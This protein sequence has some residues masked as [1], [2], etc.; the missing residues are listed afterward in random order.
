M[1]LASR[2]ERMAYQL[3]EGQ[4]DRNGDR[5]TK[6]LARVAARVREWHGPNPL[7]ADPLV[8]AAWLHDSVED[9]HTTVATIATEVG[10]RVALLVE[11]LTRQPGELYQDYVLRVAASQDAAMIKLADVIDNLRPGG[12][13]LHRRY[14]RVL[15]ILLTVVR[16]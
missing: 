6:H 8:A 10:G 5:Y 13:D 1:I 15:P 2:A 14:L 3:H 16:P 12:G 9:G 4:V 11:T 7:T